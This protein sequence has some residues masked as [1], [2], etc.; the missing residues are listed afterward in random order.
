[1]PRRFRLPSDGSAIIGCS[2]S[3]GR[4]GA[5][6]TASTP[7]RSS[8]PHRP[9]LLVLTGTIDETIAAV[10]CGAQAVGIAAGIGSDDQPG[11]PGG[12]DSCYEMIRR[13]THYCRVRGVQVYGILN[14]PADPDTAYAELSAEAALYRAGAEYAVVNSL[15]ALGA[16]RQVFPDW[17]IWAGWGLAVHNA[18]SVVDLEQAGVCGVVLPPELTAGEIS[19]IAGRTSLQLAALVHQERCTFYAGHCVSPG[20]LKLG[21]GAGECDHWCRHRYTLE[22]G[23]ASEPGGRRAKRRLLRAPVL[24]ALPVVR[25]LVGAGPKCLVVDG[26]FRGPEYVAIVTGVYSAALGRLARA[27]GSFAAT[28]SEMSLL[29]LASG[30]EPSGRSEE[31][32]D[33]AARARA[34]IAAG[35][36]RIPVCMR[37]IARTGDPFRLELADSEGRTVSVSGSVAAEAAR[38]VPLSYEYLHRQLSRLGDTPFVLESLRCELDGL[39]I[40][41]VSDISDVRRRAARALELLRAAPR[42]QPIRDG[43]PSLRLPAAGLPAARLEAAVRVS[44]V[45]GA[46]AAAAAGAALICIGGE[47][48][49]PKGPLGV[50]EIEDAARAAHKCGAKLYYATSRI[51]HDREMNAAREGLRRAADVGADGFLIANLGL[52]NFA[53][54]LT[55]GA[56]VADWSL[57]VEDPFGWSL[58]STM[59]A[60]RF[61]VPPWLGL[62]RACV[63]AERLAPGIPELFAFGRV[64]LG[65]SEYCVVDGVLGG[66][67]GRRACS[68]PCMRG[69]FSLCD[70]VGHVY[71]TRC[72]R[73][74]RMHVFDCDELDL[75]DSLPR[76]RR[77]GID[78]VWLD[79][80]GEPVSRVAHVSGEYVR[81][82]CR[83][84]G[85]PSS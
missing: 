59:G 20:V 29:A 85:G 78:R 7:G 1:M 73:S 25:E 79:L 50:S 9:T 37:A 61:I 51:V 41:P 22:A 3:T 40:V 24:E 58:L 56:V 77:M 4:W 39:A 11:G 32:A 49:V 19:E 26:A 81:A 74:C 47:A 76:L 16:A 34:R 15:G 43:V 62:D 63:L 45:E 33:A 64:E 65:V 48:F 14:S 36:P 55:P 46:T 71:P 31:K 82:A 68:A 10:S 17:P 69:P 5:I 18:D 12:P 57:S 28:A 6:E 66:R 2:M 44:G 72:D 53:A 23:E 35:P 13:A 54:Q 83:A 42:E 70:S 52:V 21:A 38:T 8:G 27:P 75:I 30:D 84:L 80:R 60:A 67:S